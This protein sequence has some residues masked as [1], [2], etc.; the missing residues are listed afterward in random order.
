MCRWASTR[1]LNWTQDAAGNLLIRKPASSR[2]AER[3]TVVLQGHVGH[4]VPAGRRRPDFSA[5]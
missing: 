2:M 1:S 4:G 5:T 3:E